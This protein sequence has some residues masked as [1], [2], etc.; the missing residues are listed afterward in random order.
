[1]AATPNTPE[2]TAEQ[3][4]ELLHY[5]PKTGRLFWKERTVDLF[6]TERSWK[7][8][9]KRYA[10]REAF[11]SCNVNGYRHGS[12]FDV[13]ISAHKLVWLLAH[14]RWP[15]GHIDHINGIRDDNRLVNIREVS[16]IQNAWNMAKRKDNKS[17]KTGVLHNEL[18]GRWY[19]S[20]RIYGTRFNLGSYL[21]KPEAVAARK[22]AEKVAGFHANHGRE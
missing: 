9:N 21:T 12:V 3:A 13:S 11:T 22:A 14:G 8:W 15:N 4:R 18:K 17:G 20:I 5:S 2:L 1:M 10:G 6:A 19:A 7:T 16:P